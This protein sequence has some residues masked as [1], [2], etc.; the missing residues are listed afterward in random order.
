MDT[1]EEAAPEQN[2]PNTQAVVPVTLKIRNR[3]PFPGLPSYNVSSLVLAFTGYADE[4]QDLLERLAH[5]TAT[6]FETHRPILKGALVSWHA[7]IAEIVEFEDAYQRSSL[8]Q[9]VAYKI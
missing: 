9:S 4:V 1:E 3:P 6:Y 8:S 5:S 7:K 2:L